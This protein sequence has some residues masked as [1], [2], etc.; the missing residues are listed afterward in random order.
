VWE[1]S[2]RV[3]ASGPVVCERAVYGGG[4]TWAHDSLGHPAGL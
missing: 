1:V 3:E 2:T 4:R